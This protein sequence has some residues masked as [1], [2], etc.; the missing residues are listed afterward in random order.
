[1]LVA[2]S[3]VLSGAGAP[4]T[5][6]APANQAGSDPGAPGPL[7]ITRTGYDGGDS[8]FLPGGWS[9]PVELRARLTY[10]TNLSGGPFPLV[11]LLH[12]QHFT[13]Y[14]NGGQ[15]QVVWPCPSGF[16]SLP[17]H[18]GYDYFADI[19]ASHGYIVVSVSANG[20]NALSQTQSTDHGMRA[21]GELILQHLQFWASSGA[22]SLGP[23]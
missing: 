15:V 1:L 6:A 5:L 22:I 21:R 17:S 11:I 19:L 16:Q 18:L 7:A 14:S 2:I 9:E 10:P 20:I 13:C 3:I 23:A 4:A 12:G 8:F